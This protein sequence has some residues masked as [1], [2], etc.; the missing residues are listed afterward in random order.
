MDELDK[1]IADKATRAFYDYWKGRRRGGDLPRWHE[2]DPVE[3]RDWLGMINVVE[4][5]PDDSGDRFR[6]R[7]H[8]DRL[9]EFL[10]TE[11][12]GRFAHEIPD[13][14]VRRQATAGYLNVMRDG[15]PKLERYVAN[16]ALDRRS[17]VQRL[18]VPVL[19]DGTLLLISYF[20][21]DP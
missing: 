21:I 16:D 9:S 2:F 12:T 3:M 14:V 1:A 8:G 5:L 11:M 6:Y 17:T 20:R 4:V 13:D 10:G 15:A 7:V 19:D 18:T